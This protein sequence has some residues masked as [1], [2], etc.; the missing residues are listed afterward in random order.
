M[1]VRKVNL[2]P[3]IWL[4]KRPRIL[5]GRSLCVSA[6][7]RKKKKPTDERRPGQDA[8]GALLDGV[9]AVPA[10]PRDHTHPDRDEEEE[11][12]EAGEPQVRPAS[13]ARLLQQQ[14]RVLDVDGMVLCFNHGGGARRFVDP[15]RKST[16]NGRSGMSMK[17]AHPTAITAFDANHRSY[18][19][20]RPTYTPEAVAQ[21]VEGLQLTAG[22]T[23]VEIGSGTGKLTV[24][25]A[26]RG[27]HIVAV[28]PSRG[29]RE[30]FARNLPDI[31]QLDANV[32]NIPLPDESA[33][34]VVIA[35]AYHWFD[36]HD[37]LRELHRVLK[38]HGRLGLLWNNYQTESSTWQSQWNKISDEFQDE[39][40]RFHDAR[41]QDSFRQ[42]PWF[43]M[44][45]REW[46]RTWTF[47]VPQGDVWGL[48]YT[49]SMIRNLPDAQRNRAQE[50]VRRRVQGAPDFK[51]DANG[52][53][54]M[55]MQVFFYWTECI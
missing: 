1:S 11:D 25:L 17:E 52:N 40:P 24:K 2:S 26:H 36:D 34:A 19:E 30:T 20:L 6:L 50:E 43:S 31:Q 48:L 29:M 53:I 49:R 4:W 13:A 22:K 41:W 32:Y 3:L 23:L 16:D 8:V 55:A 7:V 5:P 21:V 12:D 54:D 51:L 46:I 27:Y 38:P 10:R 35:Q 45:L 28:E 47:S 44:P 18:D 33:D 37:A 39:H 42:Q 15:I 9:S 14:L